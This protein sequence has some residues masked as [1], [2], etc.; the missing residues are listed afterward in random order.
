MADTASTEGE[1][2]DR[3]CELA[4][5]SFKSDVWKLLGFPLARNEKEEKGDKRTESTLQKLELELKQ[6]NGSF[7]DIL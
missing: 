7:W 1:P 3:A 4:P 6:P 2:S 5:T